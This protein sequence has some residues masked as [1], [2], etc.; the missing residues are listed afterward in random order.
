MI[1]VME[2][3][4]TEGLYI[5]IIKVIYSKLIAS[6]MSLRFAVRNTIIKINMERRVYYSYQEE[7]AG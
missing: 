5:K 2:T 3:L 1:K 4:K 7:Q 6:C